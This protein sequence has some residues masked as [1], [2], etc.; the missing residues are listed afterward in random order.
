MPPTA[1]NLS[2]QYETVSS[3]YMINSSHL[4]MYYLQNVLKM[5]GNGQIWKQDKL[6]VLQPC[7]R[8]AQWTSHPPQEQE[9]P[10]SNRVKGF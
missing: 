4:H 7:G 8:V 6:K 9:D 3:T 1:K 2:A 5:I 10:G